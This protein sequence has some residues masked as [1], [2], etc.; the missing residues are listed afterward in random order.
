MI[1]TLRRTLIFVMLPAMLLSACATTT[2]TSVWKDPSYQ[3]PPGKIM[4]V[5]VAKRPVNRRISEDEFVR[6]LKARGADAVASYAVLPDGQQEDPAAIGAKMKELG[7][8]AVLITRLTDKKTVKTLVPGTV[9]SPPSFYGTWRDYY[10]HG[11]QVIYT[12]AYVAEDEYAL[13]ETNLYNAGT[14][15]LIWSALSETEIRGSDQ[16]LIQSFIGVMVD[17]MVDEQ[18]FRSK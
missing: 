3:G 4:V 1:P 12:P 16:K 18:L 8:D 13:M 11:S 6:R 5:G 2:L 7:A 14:D 9:Y 15:K 17:A 10:R